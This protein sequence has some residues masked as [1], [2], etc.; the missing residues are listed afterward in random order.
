MKAL[1]YKDLLALWKYCRM[2]LLMCGCFLF[3]SMFVE[4]F[5]FLQMYPM[6]FAGIL[7]N[8]LIAYDEHDRWDAMVLTMPVTRKQYVTAKYL[9]GLILQLS[10]LMLTALVHGVQLVLAGDFRWQGYGTDLSLLTVLGVLAPSMM[11]PF[12]FRNGS[13]KGR[14]AYLITVGV[15]FGIA[16]A[17]ANVLKELNLSQIQGKIPFAG[18]AAALAAALYPASWVLSVRWYEKREF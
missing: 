18:L 13:E 17:G 1:I 5:G 7:V 4:D 16:V 8:S 9:A 3:S 12:I 11:L 6:I 14:M 10:V 15:A 2:Y